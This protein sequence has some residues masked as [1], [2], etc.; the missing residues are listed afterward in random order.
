MEPI[1]TKGGLVVVGVAPHTE[2][3]YLLHW[4][5]EEALRRGSALTLVN[6]YEPVPGC[7]P[8]AM[9]VPFLA[10]DRYEARRAADVRL[11]RLVGWLDARYPTLSASGL[12]LPGAPVPVLAEEGAN[13]GLLVVGRGDRGRIAEAWLGST[14]VDVLEAVRCPV[15]AVPD[16]IGPVPA[17]GPVVLGVKA[18][19]PPTAAALFALGAAARAGVPLWVVHYW[20][21]GDGTDDH[22]L[23]ASGAVAG[24]R[25]RFPDVPVYLLAVEGD[26]AD[27]LVWESRSASLVVMGWGF[28]R[29]LPGRLGPVGAAVLRGAACPVV[30]A[31]PGPHLRADRGRVS[32]MYRDRDR[33]AVIVGVNGS[34][35]S[36][37][38]LRR[39]VVEARRAGA[40]LNLTHAYRVPQAALVAPQAPR[41]QALKRA[42]AQLI[43]TCLAEA[44]GGPPDDLPIRK[45]V[46]ENTAPGPALVGR[47]RSENDLI[48]VGAGR[49]GPARCWRRP[50]AA[51]CQRHAVCPL[52]VVQPPRMVR[53]LGRRRVRLRDLD[54]EIAELCRT[55]D[56]SRP[57]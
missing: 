21:P 29:H 18:G 20:L 39:A 54:R 24:V 38:A 4:S 51:Y 8:G 30:F 47:V 52:L 55:T 19:R 49:P 17:N 32:T 33:P 3:C 5:A 31:P 36:L 15:V 57:R 25:D 46:V 43:D 7:T 27:M 2:P 10:D 16:R 50:V 56:L 26:A 14:A 28:R 41:R 44:L 13:A 37:Q 40:V 9:P 48:V 45:S 11:A 6:A 12:A 23:V 1:S 42:A 22:T 53:E 34:P 35:T